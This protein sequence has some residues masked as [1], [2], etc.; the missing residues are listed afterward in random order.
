[1]RMSLDMTD[2]IIAFTANREI[3]GPAENKPSLQA[4]GPF[5]TSEQN[6]YGRNRVPAEGPNLRKHFARHVEPGRSMLA[7]RTIRSSMVTIISQKHELVHWEV[8]HQQKKNF[9]LSSET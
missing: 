6:C 2:M 3:T 7:N 8:S 4:C 9:F 1:M 5:I